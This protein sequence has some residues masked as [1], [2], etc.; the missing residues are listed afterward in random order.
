MEGKESEEN[1]EVKFQVLVSSREI[2]FG[3]LLH[4]FFLSLWNMKHV[5]R[6]HKKNKTRICLLQ[7]IEV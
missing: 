2:G 6:M 4:T 5:T 1:S 3:I 7:Q